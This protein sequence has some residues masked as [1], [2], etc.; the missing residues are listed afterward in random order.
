MSEFS[1]IVGLRELS[2][3]ETIRDVEANEAERAALAARFGLSSI[4][5]LRASLRLRRGEGG[6]VRLVGAFRASVVQ[7][8]VVTLDPLRDEIEGGIDLRCVPEGA[9]AAREVVVDPVEDV[10]VL[11]G[12]SID[13][14]EIVAQELAVSLDPYPRRP[15][16][17]P[18]DERASGR[19]ADPDAAAHPFSALARLGG[20][21]RG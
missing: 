7:T 5:E 12:D 1:R 13:M 10:E 15:D 8:C 16:A 6:V 9:S 14:G 20:S 2:E 11:N 19:D 21:R 17:D 18:V 4:E 3:R